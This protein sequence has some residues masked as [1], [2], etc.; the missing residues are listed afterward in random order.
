MP[1]LL[2]IKDIVILGVSAD[3]QEA[4]LEFAEV[5]SE[6]SRYWLMLKSD[7]QSLRCRWWRLYRAFYA[8]TAALNIHCSVNASSRTPVMSCQHLGCR[9]FY[10]LTTKS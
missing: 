9:Q 1:M 6:F 10:R 3:D 8:V 5:R 2:T 7:D 4:A